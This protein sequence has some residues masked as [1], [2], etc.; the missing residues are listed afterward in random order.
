[1]ACNVPVNVCPLEKVTATVEPMKSLPNVVCAPAAVVVSTWNGNDRGLSSSSSKRP[2]ALTSSPVCNT[3]S[4]DCIPVNRRSTSVLPLATANV[5]GVP[6]AAAGVPGSAFTVSSVVAATS[7]AVTENGE[8][9]VL[10]S[11]PAGARSQ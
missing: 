2:F 3:P 7:A 5:T 1:F 11:N 4:V 10:N 9:A 6:V 8:T